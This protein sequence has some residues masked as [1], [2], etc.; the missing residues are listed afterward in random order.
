MTRTRRLSLW[1]PG[2]ELGLI[3]GSPSGLAGS[4]GIE[5]RLTLSP[6][7]VSAAK[8]EAPPSTGLACSSVTP[9]LEAAVRGCGQRQGQRGAAEQ[10]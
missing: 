6:M 8:N 5:T 2:R 4:K 9:H 1:Q 10:P 3:L 7:S